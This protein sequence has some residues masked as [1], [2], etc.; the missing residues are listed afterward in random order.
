MSLQMFSLCISEDF[1]ASGLTKQWA[2]Q[3]ADVSECRFL[4]FI[5]S[6]AKHLSYVVQFIALI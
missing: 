1:I 6:G 5:K 3:A 2:V 4:V